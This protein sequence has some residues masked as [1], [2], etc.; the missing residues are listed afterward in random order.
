MQVTTDSQYALRG[1]I[2]KA[3]GALGTFAELTLMK[4]G[5]I[6]AVAVDFQKLY[7]TLSQRIAALVATTMGLSQPSPNAH[8]TY[9][10]FQGALEATIQL[11]CIFLD[12]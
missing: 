8:C 12:T 1:G 9:P 10:S 5:E 11:L 4:R 3:V 6:W 7:N 2:Q